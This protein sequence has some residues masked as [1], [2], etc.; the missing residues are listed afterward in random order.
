[1]KGL[2]NKIEITLS[3]TENGKFS[4]D[5]EKVVTQ[6]LRENPDYLSTLDK[7]KRNKNETVTK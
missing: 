1:M 4:E 2:N 3:D 6:A 7:N 5:I